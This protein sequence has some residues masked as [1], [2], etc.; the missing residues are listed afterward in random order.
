M[1]EIFSY[2]GGVRETRLGDK[3]QRP[4]VNKV[5]KGEHSLRSFGPVLWN[6]M[7]P[8]NLK[9]CS[10]LEEFKESIKLWVPDCNC[11]ICKNY[12]KGLGYVEIF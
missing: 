9:E 6:T 11:K 12:I 7:L 2:I 8:E 4:N 3:F 10:S 1:K 5:N